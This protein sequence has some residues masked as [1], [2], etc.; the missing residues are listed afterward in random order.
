[1]FMSVHK[2]LSSYRRSSTLQG[3][4]LALALLVSARSVSGQHRVTITVAPSAIHAAVPS[5]CDYSIKVLEEK[6]STAR[7]SD[8]IV[9]VIREDLADAADTSG[10]DAAIEVWLDGIRIGEV[11]AGKD[12]ATFDIGPRGLVGRRVAIQHKQA[13][14]ESGLCLSTPVETPP[15]GLAQ[16]KPG[17]KRTSFFANGEVNNA[18]RSGR[19]NGSI[20]GLLGIEHISIADDSRMRVPFGWISPKWTLQNR[21]G[22]RLLNPLFYLNKLAYP[23]DREELRFTINASPVDADALDSS[24][25]ASMLVAPITSAQGGLSYVHGDYSAL[26][27]YG[28][29][30]TN[31]IGIRLALTASRSDWAY[32]EPSAEE[33]GA[34]T[35]VATPVV[36][37]AFDGGIRW[38]PLGQEDEKDNSFRLLLDIGYAYRAIRGTGG[39]D[40]EVLEKTIG[41]RRTGYQGLTWGANFV[42]RQVTAYATFINLGSKFLFGPPSTPKADRVD[43]LEGWQTVIGFRFQAPIFTL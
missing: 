23:V 26:K 12:S 32:A 29:E 35:T 6:D 40:P 14:A 11:A 33:G 34:G 17:E 24:S 25:F 19:D 21:R 36:A 9:I 27:V 3:L 22:L 2:V 8:S 39:D 37:F 18:L 31:A 10:A 28:S 13:R 38:I 43:G 20:T 1:M 30:K 41:S 5:R 15:T 42:L 7:V 16:L 4:V